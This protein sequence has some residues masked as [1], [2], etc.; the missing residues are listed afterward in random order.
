MFQSMMALM[1]QNNTGFNIASQMITT[2]K[3]ETRNDTGSEVHN[4]ENLRKKRKNG[5]ATTMTETEKM[6]QDQRKEIDVDVN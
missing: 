4:Q 6:P 2:N 1:T 3:S 5:R